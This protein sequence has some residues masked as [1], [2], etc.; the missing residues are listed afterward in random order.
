MHGLWEDLSH[1]SSALRPLFPV[2]R[3]STLFITGGTGFFGKW[4]LET[5]IWLNKTEETSISAIVLSRDP[6]RFLRRYPRFDEGSIQ[7]VR[8]D[9]RSFANSPSS[10]KIDYI[11]HAATDVKTIGSTKDELDLLDVCF[12]GTRRVLEYARETGAQR[13]LLTSSGAVYGRQPPGTERMTES[14]QGGPDPLSKSSAY[15]EGK[16][17][18][19]LLCCL[20][21]STHGIHC[22]IARC[23]AL[24][25]PYL[26]LDVGLAFGNFVSDILKDRPIVIEGDGRPYR[27][28]LYASD[29]MIWL[30]TILLRGKRRVAY[31]VGSSDAISIKELAETFCSIAG[32]RARFVVRQTPQ[33][34][35]QH[36]RY[37]PSVEKALAE[38]GLRQHVFLEE[39]IRKTLLWYRRHTEEDIIG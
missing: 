20:Y 15:G 28:Y 29:L 33:R 19:E 10:V 21:D 5:I 24:A 25:G 12:G 35:Q 14:H 36:Q 1:I 26:P 2:L 32:H 6:D 38:L 30:F 27:S 3:D 4:I 16:R 9:V 34:R 37:V 39:A 8:G 23:F 7:Y 11:I 22:T 18:S 13:V 17:L 31:N